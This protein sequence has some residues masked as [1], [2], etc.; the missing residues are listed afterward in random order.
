MREDPP[1]SMLWVMQRPR[2]P[3]RARQFDREQA[4]RLRAAGYELRAIAAEMGIPMRT[5]YDAV[6]GIVCPGVGKTKAPGSRIV[7]KIKERPSGRRR[8]V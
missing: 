4:I 2:R 6:C 3:K 1:L 5:I 8:T 7:L